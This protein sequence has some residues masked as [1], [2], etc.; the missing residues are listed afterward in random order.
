MAGVFRR[1]PERRRKPRGAEGGGDEPPSLEEELQEFE[2]KI[3]DI[4]DM[5]RELRDLIE[6]GY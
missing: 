1:F 2:G 6:Q 5:L 4:R 3:D